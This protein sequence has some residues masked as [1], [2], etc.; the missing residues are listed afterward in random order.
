LQLRDTLHDFSIEYVRILAEVFGW[1]VS[2]APGSHKGPDVIIEHVI[3]QNGEEIVDAVMFVESEIGHDIG[4][5]SEYFE[6]LVERL[7]PLVKAYQNKGVR[8]FSVVI[9]T[10]APRRLTK[11]IREH[12][13]ELEDKLG[14]KLAEGSSAFIVPVLIVKEVLPAVLVR[15]L[16]FF[17]IS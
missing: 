2:I 16:G 13:E 10:N 1:R 12:K 4:S 17:N 11:Y 6:R 5:S 15:A 8:S 9:I 14:F 3:G 7:R